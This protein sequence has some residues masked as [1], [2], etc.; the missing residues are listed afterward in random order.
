[1]ISS[2]I[3]FMNH[4]T[5]H[6]QYL[7]EALKLAQTKKGF[8]APNPAVGTIIVK[9]G[10]VIATGCHAG[11]GKMHAEAVALKNLSI[12][13]S[14]DSTVYVT[15]EP[16]CHYGK[17]APCTKLLIERQV[18]TVYYGFTDP[19]PLVSGQGKNELEEA[20]IE[21]IHLQLPEIDAFY[22]S[23]QYWTSTQ[24]PWVT[25]KLALSL[26]GK[27]AG[28]NGE[29]M[30]IT[31]KEAQIFTHQWRKQSDAILTT[32]KST[33]QDDPQLNIR[34]GQEIYQKPV[35][36]LDKNLSFPEE[37][38]LLNTAQT[39][40]LFHQE[41]IDE[42]RKKQLEA[43]GIHC[44]SVPLKN[45]TLDADKVLAYIGKQG[46]HDLLLEAGGI[47]FE[48]FVAHKNIQR[49]FIYVALKWLGA[50]MQSAFSH[51]T[52]IFTQ[53]KHLKWQV[54]GDDVVCECTFT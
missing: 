16:C 38:R 19:N 33:I 50:N 49:A 39:L 42:N 1:M 10:T 53:A 51:D 27:I 26:D 2:S 3:S 41:N 48:S 35:Y 25:A 28:I 30:L 12:A 14:V 6:I 8:C 54:L 22:E 9:H 45:D 46:V 37:A 13:Q 47:C 15:L 36:V 11:A 7:Q 4:I 20:G 24:R 17:T 44:V 31:G 23:Y 40:T 18:K 43:K 5:T 29:C 34:L 21:C 52:D 32:V